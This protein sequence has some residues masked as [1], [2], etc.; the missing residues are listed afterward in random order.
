[1]TSTEERVESEVL[2][3]GLMFIDRKTVA[4]RRVAGLSKGTKV[5]LWQSQRAKI[6]LNFRMTFSSLFLPTAYFGQKNDQLSL[7]GEA[8]VLA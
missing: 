4:H 6:P 3:F 1:M 7:L 2:Q 8:S 5:K